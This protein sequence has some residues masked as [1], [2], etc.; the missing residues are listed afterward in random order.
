MVQVTLFSDDRSV[1]FPLVARTQLFRLNP[2]APPG[3]SIADISRSGGPAL[4]SLE[5]LQPD[6]TPVGTI[7]AQMLVGGTAPPGSPALIAAHDGV[8]IG[9]TGAFLGIAGTCGAEAGGTARNAS[10][11]E[12]PANR[13][14]YGGGSA[15]MV[16]YLTQASIPQVL[17]TPGGPAVVHSSD[18]SLVTTANPAKAGE[19]LSLFAKGLGPVRA[20]MNPGQPFPANPLAAVNSPVEVLVNG[21]SAEI[22]AAVGYPGSADGTDMVSDMKVVL[23]SSTLY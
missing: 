21:T 20:S 8:I 13:R 5:I 22:L 11:S 14:I 9:G 19:V 10:F 12:D 1:G 23:I 2:S 3:Q 15:K 7:M 6:G 16:Q 4:V 17:M 18:F